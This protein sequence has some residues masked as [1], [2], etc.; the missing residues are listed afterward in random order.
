ME[1]GNEDDEDDKDEMDEMEA[2][3]HAMQERKWIERNRMIEVGN[4]LLT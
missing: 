1:G 4:I 3:R 2:K